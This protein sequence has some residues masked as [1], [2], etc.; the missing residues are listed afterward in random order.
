MKYTKSLV[1]STVAMLAFA[2]PSFAKNITINDTQGPNSAGWGAP[3]KNQGGEDQETEP[4]TIGNQSWDLEA[5]TLNG[6]SLKIYSGYDLLNGNN[7][8]GLGDIFVGRANT[9]KWKSTDYTGSDAAING[10]NNNSQFKYDYVIHFNNRS[11]YS[12][13]AGTYDVYALAGLTTELLDESTVKG[14][15]NPYKLNDRSIEGLTKVGSGSLSVTLD[16]T[17]TITLEDGSQVTGGAHFIGEINLATTGI[18]LSQTDDNLFHLTMGCGNDNLIGRVPD[19]GATLAL[20][21]FA[22]SGLSLV[23]RRLG[24]K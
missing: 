11:G 20:L 2:A 9:A 3:G 15:S 13:G 6:S 22:V 24:R 8:F 14:L 1:L 18:K 10:V 7:P 19:G 4:G 17:S 5:F 23:S 12:I 21:G 16:Q